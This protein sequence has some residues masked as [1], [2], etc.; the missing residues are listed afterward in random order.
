MRYADEPGWH[1]GIVR[2]VG[3]DKG[4]SPRLGLRTF[5]GS[6]KI[7]QVHMSEDSGQSAKAESDTKA[8]AF[9]ANN[10]Q[11]L[12][13]SGTYAEGLKI[14]FELDSIQH[15]VSLIRLLEGGPD[16]EL[17]EYSDLE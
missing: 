2:R 14:S 5:P 16:F 10:H 1:L 13:P 3:I 17:V 6:P 12:L 9:D 15:H 11:L 8:I 4:G 7:V